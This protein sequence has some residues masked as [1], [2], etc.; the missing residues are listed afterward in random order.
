[1]CHYITATLPS[2]VPSSEAEAIASQFER[3]WALLKNPH[4]QKYLLSGEQYFFTTRGHCDC[5]TTLGSKNSL[6][7]NQ[8]SIDRHVKK[9]R[10][11]GWS[12]SRIDRWLGEKSKP[13]PGGDTFNWKSLISSLIEKGNAE[14]VGVL[15]HVYTGYLE[16]EKVEI[17]KIEEV[18][19]S[20]LSEE[21]LCKIEEDVLYRF[22]R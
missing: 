9:F 6:H 10:R 21:Y 4:V 20:K 8:N 15:L 5:G 11:K 16:D 3:D 12:Q 13:K 17:E 22:K 19:F 18:G 7:T 2:N 14:F 1:M